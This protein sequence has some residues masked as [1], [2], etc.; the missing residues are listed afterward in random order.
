MAALLAERLR[1]REIAAATGW[2]EHYV[3]WLVQQACRKLGVSGQVALVR[4][5]LA[6]DALPTR[7]RRSALSP[8][9][10]FIA[11]FGAVPIPSTLKEANPWH[12][13]IW[14]LAGRRGRSIWQASAFWCNEGVRRFQ[15]GSRC[16]IYQDTLRVLTVA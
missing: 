10:V 9:I 14:S 15:Y 8:P 3:R 16:L 1:A 2:R 12:M 6:A 5:V 7:R 11:S 13:G 4:R